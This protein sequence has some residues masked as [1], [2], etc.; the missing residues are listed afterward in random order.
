MALPTLIASLLVIVTLT[1]FQHQALC[2]S[3]SFLTRI[4]PIGMSASFSVGSSSLA[5]LLPLSRTATSQ[6]VTLLLA[7]EV[8]L[9]RTKSSLLFVMPCERRD[10]E[11]LSM[12]FFMFW[13][14]SRNFLNKG[15]YDGRQALTTPTLGS[16]ADQSMTSKYVP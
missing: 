14:P 13:M 4:T 10:V 16:M 6:F 3:M 8:P 1:K 5:N 9:S 12:D 15:R 11:V 7:A 2:T